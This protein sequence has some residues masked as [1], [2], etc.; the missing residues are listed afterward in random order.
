MVLVE[1]IMLPE[2]LSVNDFDLVRDVL[3]FLA[4]RKINEVVVVD[5]E[6]KPVG[7]FFLKNFFK[8]LMED[9]QKEVAFTGNIFATLRGKLRD[10]AA[11]EVSEFME[12]KFDYLEADESVEDILDLFL[13]TDLELVPVVKENKVV[14][15]LS[16]VRFLQVLLEN[17]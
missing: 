17:K 7:Y 10:F 4:R 12:R 8:Q 6:Q 2:I 11:R 13:E 16:R 3:Q 5:L 14:G 1:E 9:S 15:M